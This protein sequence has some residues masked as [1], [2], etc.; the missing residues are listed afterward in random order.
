MQV[1]RVDGIVSDA[2]EATAEI[3]QTLQQGIKG[4][5]RQ[6]AGVIAGFRAGLETLIQRSPFNRSAAPREP[7]RYPPAG[8]PFD[9]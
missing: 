2:L 5:V 9:L 1:T 3:S 6:I 8:S 7:Q 4:P